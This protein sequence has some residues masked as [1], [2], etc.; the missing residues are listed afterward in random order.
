M[1][2]ERDGIDAYKEDAPKGD[3]KRVAGEGLGDE[4]DRL[5]HLWLEALVLQDP[6]YNSK[7]IAVLAREA[8]VNEQLRSRVIIDPEGC[9]RELGAKVTLPEGTTVRFFD[10]TQTNLNVVLPSRAG[11][12]SRWRPALQDRLQSRTSFFAAW[13]QDDWDLGFFDDGHTR[14]PPIFESE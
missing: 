11:G 10:N 1:G 4:D 13:F 3:D 14:D 7:A 12:T 2:D 6:R 5:F 9:L 8:M